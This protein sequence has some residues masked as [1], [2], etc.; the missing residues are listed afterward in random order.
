MRVSTRRC[1]GWSE[2]QARRAQVTGC[3]ASESERRLVLA[4]SGWSFFSAW[5]RH[6]AVSE[7][8][9]VYAFSSVEC[10]ESRE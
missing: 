7:V 5:L 8:C 4:E 2:E 10:D 1:T 3:W 6:S 9:E